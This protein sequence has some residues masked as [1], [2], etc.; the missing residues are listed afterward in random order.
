MPAPITTTRATPAPLTDCHDIFA[1]RGHMDQG[2]PARRG[3]GGGARSAP[4]RRLSPSPPTTADAVLRAALPQV[5]SATAPGR[6]RFASVGRT[7][8]AHV[9][10]TPHGEAQHDDRHDRQ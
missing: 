2:T 10:K 4:D 3:P 9:T 1:T 7:G 5:R 8:E 6:W